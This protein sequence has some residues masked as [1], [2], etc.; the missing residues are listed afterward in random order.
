MNVEQILAAM[1]P[2]V[3]ERLRLAVETGKWPDGNPLNEEQKENCLQAV[4]LYQAKVAHSTEHMT[5][6]AEGE[7]VHKSKS[8][9]RRELR[10]SQSNEHSIAR[11]KQDDI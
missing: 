4:L 7:I 1:T 9:L 2:E 10:E 3:Y 6:S 8:E 11:F 5:V